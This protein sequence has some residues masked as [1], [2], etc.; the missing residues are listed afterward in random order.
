[1]KTVKQTLKSVRFGLLTKITVSLAGLVGIFLSAGIFY[2]QSAMA[3]DRTTYVP[4]NHLVEVDGVKMHIRCAGEGTPTI[5]FESGAGASYLNWWAV[6]Q[7]IVQ[8]G[9]FLPVRSPGALDGVSIPA[10]SR[11]VNLSRKPCTRC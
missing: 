1:M 10:R 7:A 9:A 8:D 5:I 4:S 11:Q 6:Q 2:Q 3:R